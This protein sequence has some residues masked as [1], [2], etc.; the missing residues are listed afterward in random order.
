MSRFRFTIA[1]LTG[2]VASAAVV[3]GAYLVGPALRLAL[4]VAAGLG[5]AGY[6]LRED[7]ADLINLG[8]NVVGR[9]VGRAGRAL[10][11]IWA[12]T[13]PAVLFFDPA[14]YA[15][16]RRGHIARDP[17]DFYQLYSDDVA[18][19]AGSRT[20][21]RTVAS[22]LVPHNTHIVP[23][24]RLVTWGLV[25]SAG[26]LRRLPEVLAFA[27]YGILVAVM[28]MAGRFVA[29]ETGRTGPGLA[30][31]SLVGTSSLMLTPAAWY[32]GGQPL[33]AAFGILAALWYA[34]CFRRNG[35]W[36]GLVLAAISA[37][38]AGGFWSAGHLAGPVSA[39]Y[40]WSDGRRR[41]RL[42]AAVPLA[43]TAVAVA[44]MLSLAAR[45]MDSTVS[46]HGRT[47]REAANPVQGAITTAQ[48][49][50]ENLILANL[51]LEAET[52]PIQGIALT[53]GLL[54]FW[55]SRRWQRQ[56]EAPWF[57][58]AGPAAFPSSSDAAS[59][60]PPARRPSWLTLAFNPLECAGAAIVLGCYLL[61]WTFRGY[62]EYHNLRTL[63]TYVIVPWYDVIPQVGLALFAVGWWSGPRRPAAPIL[64][65]ADRRPTPPTRAAALGLA[66]LT[67][68]LI[69][70]NRPRVDALIRGTCPPLLP[71]ERVKF[72]I[73]RLQTM[74]ANTLLSLRVDWQRNYLRRLDQVEPIARRL[75]VGQDGIRAAFGHIYIPAATGRLLLSQ[76]ELYDV[77]AILDLPPRGRPMDPAAIRAVLGPF[78]R[79][80]PEPRPPWL[81]PGDP[82]P[83]Q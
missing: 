16:N 8:L 18:Y 27:S 33:W 6:L 74:R 38:M 37:A 46:F 22:L 57:G 39:A 36:P 64:R 13:A 12:V 73:T 44:L 81:E 80:E 53:L 79:P 28:L 9:P 50:P 20:W 66:L 69:V 29:R 63:S 34:Q 72:K 49:I 30:A 70:L 3:S 78:L 59:P 68:A 76:R 83:E 24:W 51:G 58:S 32:S 40:L 26:N 77:A 61:E 19:V 23:A 21:D 67:L 15:P 47:V 52:T 65:T 48:A 7:L 14:T 56:P 31:T 2:V 75:G 10:L 4:L 60:G 17:R 25:A 71:S 54:L 62:F 11:F 35:R 55:V 5:L 42:A 45:P 82:W 1:N 41:C 43:A